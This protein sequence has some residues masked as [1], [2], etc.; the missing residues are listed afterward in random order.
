MR[1]A[2]LSSRSLRDVARLV[3]LD[4]KG[5]ILLVRYRDERPGRPSSY[6]AAP[7]GALEQSETHRAA[8]ARELR[9]ET[10][11]NAD[12]GPELWQRSF[13]V[14]L[15]HGPVHQV[16]R[17]FL[18]RL[19]VVTPRVVNSSPE[20]IREHRWWSPVEL[21]ATPEVVFPEGLAASLARTLNL[22][23]AGERLD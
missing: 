20:A 6:W 1:R 9:E 23:L 5:S 13:D 10:G 19:D 7:G 22:P 14:D 12:I 11:L 2:R 17:Y 4:A 8:A 15:G 18:V 3:L 21:E 16:E